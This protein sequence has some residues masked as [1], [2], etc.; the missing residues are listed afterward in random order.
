MFKILH[1]WR[2]DQ[3]VKQTCTFGLQHIL[4]VVLYITFRI[5]PKYLQVNSIEKTWKLWMW[6]RVPPKK[7]VVYY[8]N[9]NTWWCL[10]EIKKRTVSY[11]KYSVQKSLSFLNISWPEVFKTTIVKGYL[12][13][14]IRIARQLSFGVRICILKYITEYHFLVDLLHAFETKCL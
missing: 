7:K 12:Y 4:V 1:E 11:E 14:C 5:F 8:D 3:F 2:E 9:K 13:F 6:L 10:L